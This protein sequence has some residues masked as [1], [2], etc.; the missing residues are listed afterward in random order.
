MPWNCVY[1]VCYGAQE[2]MH[3]NLIVIAS[4]LAKD[5]S[6]PLLADEVSIGRDITNAVSIASNSVSRR[7]CCI[8]RHALADPDRRL[9]V[10]ANR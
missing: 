5:K 10:E 2:T 8:R 6:I 3:P 7:H 1:E 4:P 9:P